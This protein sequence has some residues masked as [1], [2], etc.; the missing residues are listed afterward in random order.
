MIS[1]LPG[2]LVAFAIAIPIGPLVISI[3]PHVTGGTLATIGV[4]LKLTALSAIV[5]AILA[6]MI[7]NSSTFQTPSKATGPT[8]VVEAFITAINDHN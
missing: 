8:S 1:H 7:H 3:T 5:V 2:W 6:V 4:S